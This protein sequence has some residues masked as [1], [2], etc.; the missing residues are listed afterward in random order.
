M[1]SHLTPT[2]FILIQGVLFLAGI[3]KGVLGVGLPLVAIPLLS[4]LVPVPTAIM[5]LVVST[6]VTNGFQ[7]LQGGRILAVTG[8]YWSLMIPFIIA[9]F[10]ATRF[11]LIL[12]NDWLGLAIG[13]ILVVF[14]LLHQFGRPLPIHMGYQRVLNPIVGLIAGAIGGIS[15]FYGPVLMMYLIALN[16]PK[17][18]FVSTM[19][20]LLFAGAVPLFLSL[21]AYGLMR[22]NEFIMSLL[23]LIPVF[24]GLLIGQSIR[25]RIPE[26]PFQK[27][28]TVFLFLTG[29]A[30]I[31]R[32]L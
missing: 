12:H 6:L 2:Q 29:A 8:N 5:I 19:S 3:M 9:I 17:A 16:I 15:S 26:Q 23:G 13:T 32:S 11:L 30:L 4:L 25:R 21:L 24:S 10:L 22:Q 27:A 1:I 18:F 20:T 28:L 7:A 31:L 14:T